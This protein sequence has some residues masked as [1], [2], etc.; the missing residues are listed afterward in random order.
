[1]LANRIA[2]AVPPERL[3]P[4]TPL[5]TQAGLILLELSPDF[6][7]E[8]ALA[9]LKHFMQTI[10]ISSP[11]RLGLR[12]PL[13]HRRAGQHGDFVANGYKKYMNLAEVLG[14]DMIELDGTQ[15]PQHLHRIAL[16][17]VRSVWQNERPLALRI[18]LPDESEGLIDE[19]LLEMADMYRKHG[20]DLIGIA[21]GEATTGNVLLP[22]RHLSDLIRNEVHLPTMLVGRLKNADE[23]DTLILSA[24]ADLYLVQNS[25]DFELNS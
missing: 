13:L 23:V 4:D 14:V 6:D 2:L 19:E 10:R 21:P 17:L 7:I 22:Q 25:T 11:A 24:R 16:Q 12:I 3:T 20:C 18:S 8:N 9:P 15:E 1:M 5:V